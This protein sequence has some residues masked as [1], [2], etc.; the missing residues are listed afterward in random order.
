MARLCYANVNPSELLRAEI[1]HS[2]QDVGGEGSGPHHPVI[3][4]MLG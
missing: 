2:L 4:A 1:L 3:S